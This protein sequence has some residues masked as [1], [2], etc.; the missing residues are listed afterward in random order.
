MRV[1]EK[2]AKTL[3]NGL[4]GLAKTSWGA[5]AVYQSWAERES[6]FPYIVISCNFREGIHWAQ[7]NGTLTI[8]IFTK[9]NSVIEAEGIR[10]DIAELLDRQLFDTDEGGRIRCYFDNDGIIPDEPEICHLTMDFTIKYWRN[11]FIINLG[12]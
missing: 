11:E 5:T 7:R 9:G 2:I 3:I 4:S 6:V 10:N 1:T 12:G 8:D